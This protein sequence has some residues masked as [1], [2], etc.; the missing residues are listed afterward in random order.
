MHESLKFLQIFLTLKFISS[1]HEIYYV[2]A[3]MTNTWQIIF[4]HTNNIQRNYC[5]TFKILWVD[6]TNNG[7][8]CQK[9]I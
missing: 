5:N 3:L 6:F 7:V 9:H 8:K 2:K 4:M 1:Q